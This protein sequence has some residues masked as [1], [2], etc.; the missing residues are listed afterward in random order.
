MWSTG[1]DHFQTVAKPLRRLHFRMVTPIR[2]TEQVTVVRER[3]LPSNCG[4]RVVIGSSNIQSSNPTEEVFE[5]IAG[6]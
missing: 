6:S 3:W 2:V 4:L 5:L 1:Q